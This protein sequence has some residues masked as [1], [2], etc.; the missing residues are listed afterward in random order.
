M[1][2][3]MTTNCVVLDLA[4]PS[5]RHVNQEGSVQRSVDSVSTFTTVDL[6]WSP[7][8]FQPRPRDRVSGVSELAGPRMWSPH[9]FR[10]S[11]E[12]IVQAWIDPD[13]VFPREPTWPPC[14]SFRELDYL[15]YR[16]V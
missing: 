3:G 10:L 16:R 6:S 8:H 7:P 11:M 2:R 9:R 4:H 14:A 5:I 1:P 12:S 13:P 15:P